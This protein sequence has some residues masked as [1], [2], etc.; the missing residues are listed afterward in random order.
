M[1]I[2]VSAGFFPDRDILPGQSKLGLDTALQA[3]KKIIIIVTSEFLVDQS[4]TMIMAD[5]ICCLRDNVLT[6]RIQTDVNKEATS[7][8]PII[9]EKDCYLPYGASLLAQ[10]MVVCPT[11]KTLSDADFRRLMHEI[12]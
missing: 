10:P 3:T 11:S 7:I 2:D 8:I 6:H 4:C 9:L 1:L 5:I 12:D